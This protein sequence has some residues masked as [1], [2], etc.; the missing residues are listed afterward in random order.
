MLYV[1]VAVGGVDRSPARPASETRRKVLS[2]AVSLAVLAASAGL[3]LLP[4][5][6]AILVL[7]GVVG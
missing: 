6:V 3:V 4:P 1:D 2:L 7:L 5:A